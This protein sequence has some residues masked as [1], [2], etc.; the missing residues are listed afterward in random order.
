MD[1]NSLFLGE[2]RYMM[3]CFVCQGDLKPFSLFSNNPMPLAGT[4]KHENNQMVGD[5]FIKGLT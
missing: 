1:K 4:I 5:V 3:G 2:E